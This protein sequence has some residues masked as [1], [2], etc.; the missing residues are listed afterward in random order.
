MLQYIMRSVAE[1]ASVYIVNR[2]YRATM[3]QANSPGGLPHSW[4]F[5]YLCLSIPSAIF[6]VRHDTYT[7]CEAEAA[8]QHHTWRV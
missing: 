4:L 7:I 3:L 8:A 6:R 5:W 2:A 1:R